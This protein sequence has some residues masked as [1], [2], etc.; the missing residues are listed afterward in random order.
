MSL[1]EELLK[2]SKTI[3]QKYNID[4]DKLLLDHTFAH[5]YKNKKRHDKVVNKMKRYGI[6]HQIIDDLDR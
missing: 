3:V 2:L 4:E 1:K 6:E 5:M